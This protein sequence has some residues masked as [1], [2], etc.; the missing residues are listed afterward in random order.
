MRVAI[1]SDHAGFCQKKVLSDFVRGLGHEVE[2]LGPDTDERVD[3]PDFADKVAR[4][5]ASGEA[6][7]GVLICG[8]GLG[9]AMT[10]DKV[11]GIRAASVQT[12]PFATLAREHNDA[13]VICLSGR[14]VAPDTNQEIIRAFLTCEFAGG[15]HAGRVEK[16]MAEDNR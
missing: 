4:A 10:A 3:Y 1:A 13:N 7:R 12:V 8:T 14:F 5:V 15:R 2:D 6:D 9:M 11:A 16:I